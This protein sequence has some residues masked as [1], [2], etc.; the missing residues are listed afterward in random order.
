MKK[1]QMK[2]KIFIIVNLQ[3]WVNFRCTAKWISYIC[4]YSVLDYFPI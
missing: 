3:C 2:E 1:K 4:I